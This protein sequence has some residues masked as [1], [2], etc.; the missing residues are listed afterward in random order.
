MFFRIFKKYLF[1]A[2]VVFFAAAANVQAADSGF[3][4]KVIFKGIR[5]EALLSDIQSISDA[6]SNAEHPMASEYLLQKMA[7]NDKNN[8][9]KLLK[10]RGLYNA[11]VQFN[12]SPLKN[13]YELTFLFELGEAYNLKSINMALSQESGNSGLV[14]PDPKKMGLYLNKPFT[15]R[16]VLDAED[17]LTNYAKRNGFPFAKISGRDVEVDHKDRSVSILLALDTGPKAV[18]GRTTFTGLANVEED[19]VAGKLPWK[20]GD[21]YNGDLIE[22]AR[23]TISNLGL[24]TLTHITP[25]AELGE[26]S[27]IPITINVTERKHKSISVGLNYITNEGPGVKFS[28]E[29]RNLFN[30]GETLTTNYEL[31]NHIVTAEGTFKK[32]DFIKKNQTLRLSIKAGKENTDAYTSTSVIGSGF[33]D[34]DLT[35]KVHAGLGFSLKSASVEQLTH[36]ERFHYLSFPFYFNIDTTN[37]LLDPVRGHRLSL[38]L[39]PYYEIMGPSITFVKTIASYKLYENIFKNPLTV[40]ATSVRIGVINGTGREDLAPDER[41]YAGGGGSIRGYFYQR[42]GPLTDGTPVGG[43]SL[44]EASTE[45]RVKISSDFG[46]ACFLDGGTAFTDS[47]FSSGEKLHWGTG[48]GI[49]YYTP[50]G[51]LRLDVGFPIKKRQGIDKSY[52]IYLSLGQAF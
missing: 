2:L 52:Q 35:K 25:G 26:G 7:D 24:F 46:I 29:N 6:V 38:Q 30:R 51:P 11:S 12:I 3:S 14:L 4:Y 32:Q 49:R 13:V 34:R 43:K 10:S 42:V 48:L 28:W 21:P 17:N 1:I 45:V 50:V 27:T 22:N 8:F 39:T 5:D 9:L 44:M 31:S 47:L 16:Q 18:F 15:S 41:F 20:E 33:F 36:K 40:I 19:Y 23:E 37:D